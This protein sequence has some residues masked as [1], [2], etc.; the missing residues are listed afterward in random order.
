MPLIKN[1]IWNILAVIIPT[2]I[3]IPVLGVLARKLG[4]ELFGVFTLVFAL[5]GYASIFDAGFSRAVVREIALERKSPLVIKNVLFTAS[6][7]IFLLGLLAALLLFF[8]SSGLTLLLNVSNVY[9]EDVTYSLKLVSFI[10]PVFLFTL[11]WLSY[12]EG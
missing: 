7:F 6:T 8:F 10:I 1:S 2:I 5:M 11:I 9:Y 12:L 4:I 3:A